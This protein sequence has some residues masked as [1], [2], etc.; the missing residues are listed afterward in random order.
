MHRWGR[1]L[2]SDYPELTLLKGDRLEPC[3]T[4]FDTGSFESLTTP[5]KVVFWRRANESS[6]RHRNPIFGGGALPDPSRSLTVDTLHA[7]YLGVMKVWCR[8]CLWTFLRSGVY[9]HEATSDDKL[10]IAVLAFRHRLMAWYKR[11]S[12]THPQ[13]QLTRIVDFSR[14]WLGAIAILNARQRVPRLGDLCSC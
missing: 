7:L 10:E 13:E 14:K 2:T 1:A 4:L 6:W 3:G 9:G 5:C 12:S 11:R 8:E